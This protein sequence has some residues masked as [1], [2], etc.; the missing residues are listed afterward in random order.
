ML[1]VVYFCFYLFLINPARKM[2]ITNALPYFW[3]L[4]LL[5]TGAAGELRAQSKVA[6][7]KA[8]PSR[9]SQWK[10][11]KGKYYFSHA[12]IYE[13]VLKS[14]STKGELWIFIDPVTGSMC[15]QR[16]SSYGASD[17]MNDVILALPNGQ[18]IA[19]GSDENGKKTRSIFQN[20]ALTPHPEDVKFQQ[21]SFKEQCKPTG[22]TRKDFGWES[23]EHTL[24]FT[25]TTEKTKLWLATVPFGMYPLYAFDEWGGDAQLPVV[26]SFNYVLG[27]RQL[28]TE[29][30][31]PY[32]HI[33]LVSFESNPYSLD[34]NQYPK[35][36]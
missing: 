35:V 27:P 2:K 30:D 15:F 22:Q 29:L 36:K 16:E 25:R 34:L 6:A 18:Y 1:S 23:A 8:D 24:S 14:D 3:F 4:L 13:Y 33:K 19:C 28:I 21:D 17:D 7:V 9:A 20:S 5:L 12:L 31:D 10:P 32:T 26:L 11:D